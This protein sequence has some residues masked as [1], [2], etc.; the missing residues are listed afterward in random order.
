[1]PFL[2][3]VSRGKLQIKKKKIGVEGG[4]FADFLFLPT[5]KHLGMA[6]LDKI[7]QKIIDKSKKT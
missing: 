1:M 5:C 2:F 7:E 6:D 4:V 3:V